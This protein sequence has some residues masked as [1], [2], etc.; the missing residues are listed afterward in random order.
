[1]ATLRRASAGT[2]VVEEKIDVGADGA[3]A[4]SF[5]MRENDVWLVELRPL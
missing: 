1:V 2:P 4:R 5:P 3:F